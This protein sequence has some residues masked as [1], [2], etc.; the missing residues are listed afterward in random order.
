M[1]KQIDTVDHE[2]MDLLEKRMDLCKLIGE[3]K[4][5]LSLP[6]YDQAREAEKL[7]NIRKSVKN[8][9]YSDYMVRLFSE[10]M[11]ESKKLQNK[12]M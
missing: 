12:L 3:E 2:L 8:P 7:D 1:R 5:A 4:K 9:E 6:V 10:I 11:N